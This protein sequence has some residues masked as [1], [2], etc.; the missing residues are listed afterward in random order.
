MLNVHAC[1]EESENICNFTAQVAEHRNSAQRGCG[2]DI[3]SLGCPEGA[4]RTQSW[5]V[6]SGESCLSRE[7]ALDHPSGPCTL[8]HSVVRLHSCTGPC[9]PSRPSWRKL[10]LLWQSRCPMVWELSLLIFIYWVSQAQAIDLGL[11]FG[12]KVR[13]RGGWELPWE[14]SNNLTQANQ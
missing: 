2:L 6:G 11:G 10:P 5:A 12:G 14:H 4:I 13:E 3:P 7:A 8:T 9:H 1:G